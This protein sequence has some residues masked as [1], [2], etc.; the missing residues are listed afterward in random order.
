MNDHK[1]ITRANY[2]HCCGYW[3][4]LPWFTEPGV[5]GSWDDGDKHWFSKI[6]YGSQKA[7]LKAAIEY[8]D[9]FLKENEGLYLLKFSARNA[10]PMKRSIRNQSGVIGVHRSMNIRECG[11]YEEWVGTYSKDN[12][13]YHKTYSCNK[14][15]ETEAFKKACEFR[16]K[17]IDE[18]LT[19]KNIKALPCKPGVPYKIKKS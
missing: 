4:R 14:Y 3:L 7:A 17:G 13:Q 10:V 16:Y 1:Y 5:T 2:K 18:P 11:V 9:D 12:K 19:V 6:A 15:G 8:R